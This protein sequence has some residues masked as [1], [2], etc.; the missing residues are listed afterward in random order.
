IRHTTLQTRTNLAAIIKSGNPQDLAVARGRL[1]PF[2]RDTLVGLNYSY[3]APPGAQMLFH[4]AILIRSHDYTEAWVDER[5]QPWK[6]PEVID[7]GVTASGGAHLAGSLADLPYVLASMEQDFLV[8]DHVQ[9]LIWQDLVPSLLTNAVIARWW[10]VSQNELH[11]AALCQRAGET[12][13][14]AAVHDEE[15]R[16]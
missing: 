2:L 3:Y 8:P 6:T 13:L 7:P 12:V 11:A 15:V 16:G 10:A 14:A 1:A 5:K 9:S 4:N